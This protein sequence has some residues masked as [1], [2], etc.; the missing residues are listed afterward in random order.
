MVRIRG[1]YDVELFVTAQDSSILIALI[2]LAAALCSRLAS[3]VQLTRIRP[4]AIAVRP[5]GFKKNL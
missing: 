4:I 2:G 3:I 1:I 5:S